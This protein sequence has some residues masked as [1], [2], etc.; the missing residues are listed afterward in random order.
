[1]KKVA[2]LVGHDGRRTG[3]I[4]GFRDEWAL[5]VADARTLVNTL[6]DEGRIAPVLVSIDQEA[7][8]W[9]IVQKVSLFSPPSFLGGW[10]NIESRAEWAKL[11]QVDAAVEL[12]LNRSALNTLGLVKAAGHEVFIR[13]RPGPKTRAFGEVL[14]EELDRALG[15]KRSR[16]LKRKSFRI[17]RRLHKANI[18]AAI[19]EPAFLTEDRVVS[20]EWRS[21]YLGAVKAALYRFLNV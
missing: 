15:D 10:G 16:G 13:R 1:M 2:I 7:H 18:P 12:H 4:V 11:A 5:A 3:A 17:L 14:I 9:D 21:H 8:P 6:D 19:L 20:R